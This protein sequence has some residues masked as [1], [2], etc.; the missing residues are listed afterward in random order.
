VLH[1]LGL[2]DGHAQVIARVHRCPALDTTATALHCW[3]RFFGVWRAT[4]K[5]KSGVASSI[6]HKKIKK[7]KSVSL[8]LL[9]I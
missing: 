2:L 5:K 8:L 4:R 6:N 9:T 3:P 1:L 7:T